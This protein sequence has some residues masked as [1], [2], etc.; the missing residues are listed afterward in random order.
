ME[1][2]GTLIDYDCELDQSCEAPIP[3][4]EK[5][6][7]ECICPKCG[8]RHKMRLCWTGSGVP[9]KFCNSCRKS[10]DSYD[11]DEFFSLPIH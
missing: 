11:F 1:L 7:F 9:R 4:C 2:E 3:E 8:V 5:T 10:A 6:F